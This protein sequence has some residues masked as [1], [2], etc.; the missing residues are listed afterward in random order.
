MR[1]ELAGVVEQRAVERERDHRAQLDA[2]LA[3]SKPYDDARARGSW[4]RR[5]AA[6]AR[7]SRSSR[8]CRR[9]DRCPRSRGRTSRTETR[10]RGPPSPAASVAGG[11]SA[12]SALAATG[13]IGGA[14]GGGSSVAARRSAVPSGGGS[15]RAGD[16]ASPEPRGSAGVAS[17]AAPTRAR[18]EQREQGSRTASRAHTSTKHARDRNVSCRRSAARARRLRRCVR[19]RRL[20]SS[21][22]PCVR[23]TSPCAVRACACFGALRAACD[24]LCFD[25]FAWRFSVFG[26]L[27]RRASR[28]RPSVRRPSDRRL[29]AARVS[30]EA[31]HRGTRHHEQGARTPRDHDGIYYTIGDHAAR[32][33]D[34]AGDSRCRS[35]RDRE[36]RPPD[37]SIGMCDLREL[38]TALA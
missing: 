34:A 7:R 9:A 12:A 8:A 14:T 31:D 4:A 20:A 15:V 32:S 10:C 6:R 33:E 16:A 30:G 2:A 23:A 1:V 19:Q 24:F 36:S 3:S 35:Q 26:R 38:P 5:C 25:F 22:E 27:R 29:P 13:A 11:A 37:A 17:A 28:S 21:R 18:A